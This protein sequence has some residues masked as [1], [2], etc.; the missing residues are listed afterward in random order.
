[1][2]HL[3]GMR[4]QQRGRQRCLALRLAYHALAET[5]VTQRFRERIEAL[6][7]RVPVAGRETVRRSGGKRM[8]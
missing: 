6:V 1:M 7:E 5:A 8:G 4:A 3:V 2:Q